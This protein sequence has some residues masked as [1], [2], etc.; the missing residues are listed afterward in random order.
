MVADP[1]LLAHLPAQLAAGDPLADLD[2]LQHRAVAEAPA[3][4]VVD[5]G[6]A[7]GPAEGVEG[8]DQV[9][10]VDVV[11]DL[12]A[13]VAEDGVRSAG[14]GALHQV[15]EEAVQLG[16]GV[17]G[18]G[19][20]A[21]AEGDGRHVEV[22]PVLLHQQV[23]RRLGD[24]EQRVGGGVDRHRGVDATVSR[25]GTRAAPAAAPGLPAAAGWACRRRPCWSSRR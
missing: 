3:A 6:G 8:G 21:A 25:G 7:R 10:A 12:L 18:A 2:R 14:D 20:A 15:G 1:R 4:D 24:A 19:Q 13:V 16:A 5:G 9:G 17:L 11:A 22:A 23:G